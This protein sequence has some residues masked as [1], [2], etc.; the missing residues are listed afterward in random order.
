MHQ[1]F[2]IHQKFHILRYNIVFNPEKAILSAVRR[3][4]T[5]K[6]SVF[7]AHRLSTVMDADEIL[8][9]KNGSIAERGTHAKLIANKDGIYA[10]MWGRQMVETISRE[11]DEESGRE[12]ASPTAKAGA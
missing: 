11:D 12:D 5:G 1:Y 8:V 9:L 2:H 7:I 4:T 10:D 3:V 6:T